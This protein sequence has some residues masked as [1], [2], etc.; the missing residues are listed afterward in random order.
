MNN[1]AIIFVII[2]FIFIT[3]TTFSSNRCYYFLLPMVNPNITIIITTAI[4]LLLL[5]PSNAS[6][7]VYTIT[8]KTYTDGGT[9]KMNI[10]HL[11]ITITDKHATPRQTDKGK[12]ERKKK[13]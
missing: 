13:H 1:L 5:Y 8:S 9:R 10:N 4:F 3:I 11:L 2:T 7:S 12:L 6:F